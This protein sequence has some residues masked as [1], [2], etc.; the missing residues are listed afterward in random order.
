M[1]E[2]FTIFFTLLTAS[3]IGWFVVA[4]VML[5][6]SVVLYRR[7]RSAATALLL[8]GSAAYL[9][10]HIFWNCVL[11]MLPFALDNP[12]SRLARVFYPTDA[13]APW[14]DQLVKALLFISL[15]FPV[16][17]LLYCI[18]AARN[19]LTRRCSEPLTA[20]RSGFR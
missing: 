9:A 6:A 13:S 11:F 7:C 20:P 17:L 10:K 5:I 3:D 15:F 16:G 12:D 19:H 1:V 4:L 18:T 2:H 14:T 8:I